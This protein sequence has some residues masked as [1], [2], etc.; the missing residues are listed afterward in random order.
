[1][2][3]HSRS[4]FQGDTDGENL[5]ES[6]AQG[7]T[8]IVT[9][10]QLMATI[11]QGTNNAQHPRFEAVDDAG[12]RRILVGQHCLGPARKVDLSAAQDGTDMQFVGGNTHQTT[13]V[14]VVLHPYERLEL[15]GVSGQGVSGFICWEDAE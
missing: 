11:A 5:I 13:G 9:A 2:A 1:M 14:A 12:D 6:N 7:P 10:W 15:K 3:K 4:I 8:R